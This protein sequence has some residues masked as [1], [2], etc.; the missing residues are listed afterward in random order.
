MVSKRIA[1]WDKMMNADKNEERV[2]SFGTFKKLSEDEVNLAHRNI[3]KQ[4]LKEL[5]DIKLGYFDRLTSQDDPSSKAESLKKFKETLDDEL[6]LANAVIDDILGAKAEDSEIVSELRSGSS[7]LEVDLKAQRHPRSLKETSNSR[8]KESKKYFEDVK[9][10]RKAKVV[11]AH[12]II[13]KLPETSDEPAVITTK[14]RLNDKAAKCTNTTE[15]CPR[16]YAD[17]DQE[18]LSERPVSLSRAAYVNH[19]TIRGPPD[20]YRREEFEHHYAPSHVPYYESSGHEYE[21]PLHHH[22][23]GP[24]EEALPHY[25]DTLPTP[26]SDMFYPQ[27][28]FPAST[29]PVVE[30]HMMLAMPYRMGTMP[31][32]RDVS[33]AGVEVTPSIDDAVQLPQTAISSKSPGGQKSRL[34]SKTTIVVNRAKSSGNLNCDPGM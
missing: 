6:A 33:D 13:V 26:P 31:Q 22:D 8:L 3:S 5:I 7:D 34:L 32:A 2:S 9:A 10:K 1:E 25:H 4:R 18:V 29:Y 14:S 19:T 24:Y 12:K 23:V 30:T 15:Y 27:P 11:K 28:V 17:F 20:D 21:A 16:Q